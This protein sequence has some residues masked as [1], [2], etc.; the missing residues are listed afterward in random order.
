MASESSVWQQ[1]PWWCQP[2][3]IA[4]TAFSVTTG[5]WLLFHRYWLTGLVGLPMMTWM[6][7]FLLVYPRLMAESG[8][9]EESLKASAQEPS[10]S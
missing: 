6:G 10:E 8:L 3:S 4:L 7:F 5:S 9:L 1:K 2:W